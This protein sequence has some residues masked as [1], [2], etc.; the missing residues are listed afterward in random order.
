M[1]TTTPPLPATI[2]TLKVEK[3]LSDKR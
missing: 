2:G 3:T 1:V